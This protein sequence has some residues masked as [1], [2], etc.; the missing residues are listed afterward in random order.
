MEGTRHDRHDHTPLCRRMLAFVIPLM[1]REVAS[2]WPHTVKLLERTLR[3][4]CNQSAGDQFAVVVVGNERP[5]L[6][7]E[8]PAVRFIE[9]DYRLELSDK[10]PVETDGGS[11]EIQSTDKG[12]KLMR[13]T[14]A[15]MQDSDVTHLMMAD[16][17]DCVSCGIAAFVGEHP[18]VDGWIIES[19]YRYYEGSDYVVPIRRDFF[20]ECGTSLIVQRDRVPVPDEP[21]WDRGF[22]YYRWFIN[23]QYH[24][25]RAQQL[26]WPLKSLPFPGA[27]YVHHGANWYG[28]RWLRNASSLRRTLRTLNNRVRSRRIN[29]ALRR[30]FYLYPL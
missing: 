11:I 21:E 20:R 6:E 18:E 15:A 13:G 3:S 29:E 27:V 16:A 30:E 14:V 4:V 17:D 24:L 1:S 28:Q 22:T 12:R 9:V 19:G 7:F 23:H 8:H 10:D 5:A 25:D 2:D 26:G